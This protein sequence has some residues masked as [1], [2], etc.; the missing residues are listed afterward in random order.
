[1]YQRPARHPN[2]HPRWLIPVAALLGVGLVVLGFILI[3]TRESAAPGTKKSPDTQQSTPGTTQQS[4]GFNKSLYST[5]D[6]NS[7][8]VVANKSRALEPTNYVP[9]DLV[10]PNLPLRVPGNETMQL[11]K[12]AAAAL[13]QM[14]AAAKQE[15]LNLMVSSAYRSYSYQAN[16]YG[17]YVKSVGRAEADKTSARPGHSEHQTGLSVDVEP[18]TKKCELDT[19]FA[20]TPEGQWVAAN[21]YRYGFIIRY[22]KDKVGVTGYEYEPWHLRYVGTVLAAEM[23]SQSIETLEEFFDLPG[24]QTYN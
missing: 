12:E 16:L 19:C 1:M 18:T 11:R 13:E 21:A 2:R 23:H 9:A 15:N 10:T 20:D 6:P 14:F 8:W 3:Q 24:G 5:D 17:G 7:I 4:T 22:T